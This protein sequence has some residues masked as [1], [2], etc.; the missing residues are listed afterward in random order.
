LAVSAAATDGL[1]TTLIV[2]EL[3]AAMAEPHVVVAVKSAS[4]AVGAPPE[5]TALVKAIAAAEPFVN[6]TIFGAVAVPT[7]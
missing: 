6:V 5:T 7:G 2:Q 4:A 1:K 3:L